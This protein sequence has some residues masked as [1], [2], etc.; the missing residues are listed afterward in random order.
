MISDQLDGGRNRR[1]GGAL[2][3][4]KVVSEPVGAAV[5]VVFAAAVA[6]DVKSAMEAPANA[7]RGDPFPKLTH[8][9]RILEFALQAS[10]HATESST[11]DVYRSGQSSSGPPS[12]H[13][14][15][16]PAIE[17]CQSPRP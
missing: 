11:Q 10:S 12:Q 8:H 3:L 5:E 2:V 16:V 15:V 9:F 13:P 4:D 6:T 1:P 7:L 14:T 17:T